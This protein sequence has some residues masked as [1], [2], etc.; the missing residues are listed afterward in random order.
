MTDHRWKV[1]FKT[2]LAAVVLAAF[3]LRMYRLAGSPLSWD[4][5]WSIGLSTLG[6]H[7]ITSITALDVHPPL[8]YALFKLWLQL[9]RHELWM[10]FLSVLAGVVTVPLAC[11]TGRIWLRMGDSQSHGQR[12]G[13]L[14]ALVTTFSP[15]LLYYSQVARMFSLCAALSLAAAYSL[16][17]AI[18]T[19]ESVFFAAFILSAV[20]A[21][22]TFYYTAFVLAAL[23]VYAVVI[24]PDRWRAL[25]I[26]VCVVALLYVP[27]LA[28]AVP[29]MLER[30][31]SRAGS[32]FSV[33]DM[34]RFAADGIFGLVFAYRAGWMAVYIILL[35]VVAAG[36]LAWRRKESMRY[37]AL[38]ILAI[39][40]SLATV[41]VGAKAHMFAARYLISASPFL[42]L[43]I[44]W[45]IAV[46]WQ[47]A[48]WLG[49]LAALLVI[50][51]ALP[52]IAYYVYEKPYEVSEQFDPEVGYRYLHGKTSPE[53]I[54]FFNVLSLAGH[55]ERLRMPEDPPWSYVLR[56]DP[57]I[58][59][60]EQ[61]LT[62]RVLPAV[63][64]HR[65]LW[66]VLYKGTVAANLGLK[67][68]LDLNLY[69]TFGEWRED[70]LYL[71]YL[72]P[73][74][75]LVRLE[76]GLTFDDR[77]VLQAATFTSQTHADDRVTVRLHWT[78]TEGIE[79]SYK[80]FVHLYTSDGRLVAQHD[81]VPLNELRP[82]W[83][84]SPGEQIVDNHGLWV[85]PDAPEA[86]RL[87]VGVYNPESGARL[88]LPDGADH[89]EISVIEVVPEATR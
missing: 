85:P 61:A 26:S 78:T 47:R 58:E 41:S 74:D 72:S 31:G 28:L 79:Q 36:L 56:W 75:Q 88:I 9:G 22:Y 7:E 81:A 62:D 24:R 80:V 51:S 30:V 37:L 11:A 2:L 14:A 77:I 34:V 89:A 25:L 57:V 12:I 45:A 20:A 40:L 70:T 15:F 8:Y 83:S 50:L 32:A 17:K 18:D 82:T 55:Y 46:C 38:P 86:L 29:P 6:W 63:A 67:E 4:E 66:F 5:G 42:A 69:P 60:I 10:R 73:T 39:A 21:I 54:I 53:E 52:T 71:E 23:V 16:L 19:G 44:A 76:P 48:R 35:L 87:V 1:D 64:R 65:R 59:P 84:W 49:V 13:L 33:T 27:W 43:L 3:A 68:W